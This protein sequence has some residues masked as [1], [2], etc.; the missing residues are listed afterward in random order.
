MTVMTIESYALASFWS[1]YQEFIVTQIVDLRRS[2]AQ[3][4]QSAICWHAAQERYMVRKLGKP[5]AI[6][7]QAKTKHY[8]FSS[9]RTLHGIV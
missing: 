9:S 4:A 2:N 5:I 8:S 6:A 3:Y 1:L 7:R